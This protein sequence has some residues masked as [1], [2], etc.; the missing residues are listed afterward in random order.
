MTQ[1][2]NGAALNLLATVPGA[3]D[4]RHWPPLGTSIASG[5]ICDW[6]KES[7]SGAFIPNGGHDLPFEPAG[8]A[9]AKLGRS[10][11]T[12]SLDGPQTFP[13]S[14]LNVTRCDRANRPVGGNARRA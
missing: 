6:A 13:Q 4:K 1:F 5:C 9:G 11:R 10:P 12:R 2:E 7:E 8:S 14:V 3:F